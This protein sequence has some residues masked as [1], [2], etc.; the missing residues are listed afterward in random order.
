MARISY[1]CMFNSNQN[2]TIEVFESIRSII[3]SNNLMIIVNLLQNSNLCKLGKAQKSSNHGKSGD[4]E[5]CPVISTTTQH[6]TTK[7]E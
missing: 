6:N 7:D 5:I 3:R 1:I 4:A 2:E